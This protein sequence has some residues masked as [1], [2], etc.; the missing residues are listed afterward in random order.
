MAL[1]T[2]SSRNWL[3]GNKAISDHCLRD[4]RMFR[5]AA[6]AKEKLAALNSVPN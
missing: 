3:K 5:L 4:T 6:D 1:A 2:T